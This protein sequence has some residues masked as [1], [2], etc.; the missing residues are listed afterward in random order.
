MTNKTLLA[1]AA[2]AAIVPFSAAANR[3][4]EGLTARFE[5]EFMQMTIDHHFA[6]LRMTELAAGTDTQRNPQISEAEGTSPTPGFGASPAKATLADLKSLARRNNRMQREE[7]MTMQTFLRD[8]YGI[9][10]QPRLREDSRAMIFLLERAQPGADFN[11]VFYETFSRHHY[12]LM[13]P[14]NGCMTGTDLDHHELRQECRNMWHS[15]ISDI[16]MMR[17]ELKK[18]F[19]IADYQPFRGLEPLRGAAGGPRGDHSG[20]HD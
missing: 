20:G 3:P 14:V 5:V 1:L 18:H 16:N 13:E 11:H 8:W 7:I 10:Y 9:Q 19:G 17:H 15:Q 2:A 4:G 12:T 6:A